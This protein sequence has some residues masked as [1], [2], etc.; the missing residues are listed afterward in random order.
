VAGRQSGRDKAGKP[1][2]VQ[3]RTPDKAEANRSLARLLGKTWWQ[4]VGAI[5]ALIAV[6]VTIWA[7]EKPTGRSNSSP[8]AGSNHLVPAGN[9]SI[10]TGPEE[11]VQDF[12][13]AINKHDWLSVWSLGGK[14]LG[15]G[16]YKT[17][18]GMI[19]GYH[20]TVRDTLKGL[21]SSENTVSGYLVAHD[22]Y[23]GLQSQQTYQF[24]YLVLRG[25]I[26]RANV[27]IL[28]GRAPPGCA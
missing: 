20:C 10:A 15:Q 4:G 23:R 12:Y 8:I 26:R 14:Y 3:A 28:L 22:S 19:H 9:A 11:V 27:K 7:V 5:A 25:A 1:T 17:L 21:R 16:P 2:N 24:K 6:A 13:A 18:S